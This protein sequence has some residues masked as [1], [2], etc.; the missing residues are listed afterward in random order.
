MKE[1]VRFSVIGCANKTGLLLEMENMDARKLAVVA[2]KKNAHATTGMN[3]IVKAMC[4]IMVKLFVDL[5]GLFHI[6]EN[7]DVN[8][9]VISAN[10]CVPI[11]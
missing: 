5:N 11:Q 8:N 2:T 7:M 1:K 10:I 3:I 6:L 9:L 4:F